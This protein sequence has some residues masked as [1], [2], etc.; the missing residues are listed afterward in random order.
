MTTKQLAAKQIFIDIPEDFRL[1]DQDIYPEDTISFLK[2]QNKGRNVK[3]YLNK[4]RQQ[5]IQLRE[6]STGEAES[7]DGKLE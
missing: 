6:S 1:F 2:S 4:L 7:L 5:Y 3:K